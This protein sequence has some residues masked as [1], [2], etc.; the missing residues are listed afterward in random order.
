MWMGFL[1]NGRQIDVWDADEGGNRRPMV[2]Y[3]SQPT[4]LLV[5]WRVRHVARVGCCILHV[6]GFVASVTPLSHGTRAYDDD[7]DDDDDSDDSDD[8]SEEFQTAFLVFWRSSR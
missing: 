6:R 3:T 2:F 1:R 8:D 5:G 7:D 4:F